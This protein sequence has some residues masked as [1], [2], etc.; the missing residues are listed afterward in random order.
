GVSPRA[1]ELAFGYDEGEPP[2]T[3]ELADGRAVVFRGSI[4]RIDVSP[5]GTRVVVFDYKTGKTDRYKMSITDGRL[6]DVTWRGTKLQLAIYGE[7]AR[8]FVPTAQEVEGYYWFVD[9][10]NK[11]V[12]IGGPIG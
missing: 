11:Q 6:D 3:I 2:V 9:A 5:D 1:V 10:P 8:R 7:A 4:D 12:L